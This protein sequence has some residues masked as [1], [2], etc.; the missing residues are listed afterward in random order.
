MFQIVE[1]ATGSAENAA[2]L[3]P[4]LMLIDFT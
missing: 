3:C 1:S 2:C 4:V